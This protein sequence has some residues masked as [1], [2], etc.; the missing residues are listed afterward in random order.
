[1]K[2]LLT[3]IGILACFGIALQT[4]CDAQTARAQFQAVMAHACTMPTAPT[5]VSAGTETTSGFTVTFSGGSGAT[6]YSIN[7]GTTTSYGTTI[8][9]TSPQAITGL[10]AS[11]TYHYRVNAISSCGTTNGSDHSDT[12]SAASSWE[13]SDT[14][15]SNDLATNWTPDADTWT[16][17]GGLLTSGTLNNSTIHNK[18]SLAHTNTQAVKVAYPSGGYRYP[19]FLLRFNSFAGYW[20]SVGWSSPDGSHLN[21]PVVTEVYNASSGSSWPGTYTGSVSSSTWLGSEVTGTG[22]NT[23]VNLWIWASDP[24]NWDLTHTNW[25]APSVSIPCA[26]GIH[27][28]TGSYVGVT[29]Y[30]GYALSYGGFYAVSSN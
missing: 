27:V 5:S 25:G 18:T 10:S 24:G 26:S 15:A 23:V 9:A 29:Q 14:F 6:S 21:T 12:T 19:G 22:A 13:I 16:I 2:R 17:S 3:I 8:S 7:Y 28:D 30:G 1:M 4:D 11:T 20:Y